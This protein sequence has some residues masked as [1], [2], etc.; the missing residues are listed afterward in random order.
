LAKEALK[1]MGFGKLLGSLLLLGGVYFF[2]A[3]ILFV[4]PRYGINAAGSIIAL[5]IGV[6]FLFFFR[7]LALIGWG[8]IGLGI[9]LVF[10]N[11]MAFLQPVTLWDFFLGT[12]LM[13]SGYYLLIKGD[14]PI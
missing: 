5:T 4:G 1:F 14:I 2:G 6:F 8:A 3:N 7:K 11:G 12:A 10:I 9:L 13:A